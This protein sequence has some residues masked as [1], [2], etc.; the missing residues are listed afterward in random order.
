MFDPLMMTYH[1]KMEWISANQK[2]LGNFCCC[3]LFFCI[4]DCCSVFVYECVCLNPKKIRKIKWIKTKTIRSV[5]V[6]MLRIEV[7]WQSI[8]K[9]RNLLNPPSQSFLS[10][11]PLESH[12]FY[13]L[14]FICS[15]FIIDEIIHGA[16][17]SFG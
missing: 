9:L 11:S 8:I 17:K 12:S 5:G 13:L 15:D 2:D 14:L 3:F 1:H 7:K 10:L 6:F 4:F 16:V